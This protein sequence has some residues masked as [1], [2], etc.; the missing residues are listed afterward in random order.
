[1]NWFQRSD[2]RL[3]V[4]SD[5]EEWLEYP[6]DGN[7]PRKIAKYV[8]TRWLTAS[9]MLESITYNMNALHT[10]LREKNKENL[11]IPPE[12]HDLLRQVTLFI[13]NLYEIQLF[14]ETPKTN[15]FAHLHPLF[16]RMDV[17]LTEEIESNDNGDFVSGLREFKR[18]FQQRFQRE[19]NDQRS[20]MAIMIHPLHKDL[21]YTK[22]YLKLGYDR[23]WVDDL[24]RR[25]RETI[26]DEYESWLEENGI[27]S[28][29]HIR[30]CTNI[31]LDD[32]IPKHS[33]SPEKEL[34]RFL[35][36][37]ADEERV[38][39]TNAF[40]WWR[41]H[42]AKYPNLSRFAKKYLVLCGSSSFV[43]RLWSKGRD[44]CNYKRS[45]LGENTL[46]SLIFLKGHF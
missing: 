11:F 27:S 7:R 10:L 17:F 46:S 24:K 33:D 20:Y 28:N 45:S 32:I 34:S 40:D 16:L 18:A 14:I 41:I 4:I 13:R 44:I 37:P 25:M 21:E 36:M 43:E 2:A 19:Y 26:Q 30:I 1:M 35:E 29:S 5:E 3:P 38:T 12:W 6:H 22:H 23:E 8:E 31:F 39:F 15:S 9:Q 42:K